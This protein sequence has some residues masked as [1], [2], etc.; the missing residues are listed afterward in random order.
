MRLRRLP[1]APTKGRMTFRS[2]LPGASPII[3]MRA[4]SGPS[5]G[6]GRAILAALTEASC[7]D[8]REDVIV[9]VFFFLVC[10]FAVC[11]YATFSSVLS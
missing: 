3:A 9:I 8:T 6:T 7:C 11:V 5:A 4:E 10:A 1:E 2:V